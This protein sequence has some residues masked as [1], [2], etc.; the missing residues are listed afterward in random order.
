MLQS[1]PKLSYLIM[2]YKL[3]T[4]EIEIPCIRCDLEIK[5]TKHFA[6]LLSITVKLVYKELGYQN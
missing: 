3:F 1:N 2:K 4:T 6:V 5:E